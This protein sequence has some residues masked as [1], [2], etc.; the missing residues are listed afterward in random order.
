MESA[1]YGALFVGLIFRKNRAAKRSKLIAPGH[2][3]VSS[4]VKRDENNDGPQK[5]PRRNISFL[6]T[7]VL[8]AELTD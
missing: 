6:E 2:K 1:H 7:G 5:R 4:V 3:S 8:H